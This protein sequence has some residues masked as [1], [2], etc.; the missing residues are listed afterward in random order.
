MME[1]LF[2]LSPCHGSHRDWIYLFIF[3]GERNGWSRRLLLEHIG[4]KK[5]IWLKMLCRKQNL[6]QLDYL[7]PKKHCEW[8][9]NSPST[10]AISNGRDG[11]EFCPTIRTQERTTAILEVFNLTSIMES[12]FGWF[13]IILQRACS[14][15]LPL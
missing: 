11:T 8:T 3:K 15:A 7:F 1:S 4:V 5:Q 10:A 9:S 6:I 12:Y 13:Y 14:I 2:P